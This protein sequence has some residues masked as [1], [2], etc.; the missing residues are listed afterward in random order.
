MQAHD[1]LGGGLWSGA[2]YSGAVVCTLC[3]DIILTG[4]LAP[5]GPAPR[6]RTVH[7]LVL[8]PGGSRQMLATKLRIAGNPHDPLE[9]L[10]VQI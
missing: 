4:Q 2:A 1:V 10:T 7:S 8:L 3:I 9:N 6:K 5:I